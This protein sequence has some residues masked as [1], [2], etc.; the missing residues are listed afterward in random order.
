MCI[1]NLTNASGVKIIQSGSG[2]TSTKTTT[3]S[4]AGLQT[5]NTSADSQNE[6]AHVSGTIRFSRSKS[7]SGSFTT[8][9][10]CP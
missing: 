7:L 4:T 5:L 6:V 1:A 2:I 8:K 10:N 3:S 9:Y